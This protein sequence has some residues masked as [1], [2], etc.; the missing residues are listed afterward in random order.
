MKNPQNPIKFV[1]QLQEEN[2]SLKKQIEALL[3]D[4]AKNLKATL[5]SE[6]EEING[7]NLIATK[8]DLDQ[9]SLKNLAFELGN[10]IDNL[11]FFAGTQNGDKALL[12]CFIANNLVADR[13]LNAG[14]VVRE[15]GKLIQGGGGGQPFFATAGGKNPNGIGEA[16]VKVR[17]FIL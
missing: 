17:E 9:N 10:E 8:I 7:V 14:Q 5:K 2:N 12:T 6:V 3:K 13:G 16:I 4:K 15:L 11:F 1:E